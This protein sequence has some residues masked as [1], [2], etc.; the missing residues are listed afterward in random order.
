MCAQ[1][2]RHDSNRQGKGTGAELALGTVLGLGPDAKRI[3]LDGGCNVRFWVLQY[4]VLEGQR[5]ALS[6]MGN[7]S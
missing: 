6:C 2:G 4:D 1:R 3:D 7:A 5:V